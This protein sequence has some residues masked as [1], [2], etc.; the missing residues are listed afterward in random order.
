MRGLEP[1]HWRNNEDMSM[2]AS[3]EQSEGI[4]VLF[5]IYARVLMLGVQSALW[6]PS[7]W[8]ASCTAIFLF[9][10]SPREGHPFRGRNAPCKRQS[11]LPSHP[12]VQSSRA[13]CQD[14]IL[15]PFLL[16]PAA[17]PS[18]WPSTIRH[19]TA[20]YLQFLDCSQCCSSAP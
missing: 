13:A 4:I 17:C 12:L 14:F 16:A 5:F 9:R 7:I 19:T 11:F 10:L 2:R 18:V 3:S 8:N 1:R 6:W 15:R 20:D